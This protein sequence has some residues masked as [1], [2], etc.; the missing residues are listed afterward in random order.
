MGI[1]GDG[2]FLTTCMEILTAAKYNI[3]P[4]ICVFSDGELSQIAQAQEIPY[5][6]KT[7]TV[8][9]ALDISGVATAVGAK[10]IHLK[11]NES[12]DSALESAL[13][14]SQKGQP[15]IV[16][17]KIDYSKTTRFTKGAVKTNMK[18]FDLKTKVRFI[19]RALVRKVTG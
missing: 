16:N 3:G 11:D 15:V 10:Y 13:S 5:N 17:V 4:V 9:G 1:V 14:A 12:I 7:C 2:A 6:R 18:R 19:G 8:L